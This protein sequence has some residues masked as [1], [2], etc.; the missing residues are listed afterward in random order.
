MEKIDSIDHSE[1]LN[2][3]E[4]TNGKSFDLEKFITTLDQ[5][6]HKYTKNSFKINDEFKDTFKQELKLFSIVIANK[7]T[8][9][10]IS[11]Y[12]KYVY[13]TYF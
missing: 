3:I 6:L 4:D 5:S 11:K 1:E 8:D 2:D 7:S 12:R 10:F 13:L 9:S